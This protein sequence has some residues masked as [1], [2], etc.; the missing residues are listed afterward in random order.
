MFFLKNLNFESERTEDLELLRPSRR[1][2]KS[3]EKELQTTRS[4]TIFGK[5]WTS[6]RNTIFRTFY[7]ILV[8]QVE[9]GELRELIS[10]VAKLSTPRVRFMIYSRS[11]D[12]I[13]VESVFLEKNHDF[14]LIHWL[15][16]ILAE[17]YAS[18]NKQN[19]CRKFSDFLPCGQHLV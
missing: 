7:L 14:T 17:C 18:K 9:R 15:V 8:S 4:L 11:L 16:G 2:R 6:T 3:L 1:K 10:G 5:F 13:N 19:F 12:I